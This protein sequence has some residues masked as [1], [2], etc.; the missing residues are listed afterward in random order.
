MRHGRQLHHRHYETYGAEKAKDVMLLCN[1]CHKAIHG[2]V[3][4]GSSI[5][6]KPG[7]LAD[8]GDPGFSHL[9]LDD[10]LWRK[11]LS[12]FDAQ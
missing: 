2:L 7:S 3:P 9:G 12:G 1:Q 4:F 10:K 5:E 6:V 8:R 11:Y